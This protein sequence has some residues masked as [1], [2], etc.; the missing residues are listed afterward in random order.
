MKNRLCFTALVIAL[1]TIPVPS[2][3]PV[4]GQQ[5]NSLASAESVR[6]ASLQK[7]VNEAAR[8]GVHA[9]PIHRTQ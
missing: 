2:A 1:L 4:I 6:A 9:L 3:T 5:R 7:L 8:T